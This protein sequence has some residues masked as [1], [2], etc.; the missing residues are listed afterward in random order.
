MKLTTYKDKSRNIQSIAIIEKERLYDLRMLDAGFPSDMLGLLNEWS[1]YLPIL[2]EMHREIVNGNKTGVAVDSVQ[3]MTPLP[4]PPS[5]RDGYAFRQHV[6]TARRNR[7]LEMIPAFDEYPVFYFG[8]HR[9]IKDPGTITCMADHFEQ[10]DFEL[11]CAIVICKEGKNIRAAD[12]D[13]YI[14]GLMVM[15]DISARRL[16]MDEMLLNLGPAKGKDFATS[17]G[18]WLVTLD[19]LAD[20]ET[21]CKNG[22]TGKVWKL[23]ME[24][25][26]NGE[27][28]SSAN[29]EDMDWTFAEL[30]E[31]ASYGVSLYPGDIIGSGTCGTGCLLELNGTA[32]L[33]NSKS[34]DRWLQPGDTVDLSIERLGTLRNDFKME[35]SK[36]SILDHKKHTPTNDN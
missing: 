12:A 28:V 5:L 8:N 11:E 14:G 33:H 16:Q 35:R 17:V 18:P 29:L 24:A 34:V 10:L 4:N 32:R 13:Q 25:S 22:H 36:Y 15:N 6:A 2:Q 27:Q 7:K 20:C 21:P 9:T 1:T 30:I 3:I 31:R 19:E 23:K 26:I